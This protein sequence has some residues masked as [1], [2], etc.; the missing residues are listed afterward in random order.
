MNTKYKKISLIIGLAALAGI[1]ASESVNK[2]FSPESFPLSLTVTNLADFPVVFKGVHLT[3]CYDDSGKST[4]INFASI[5]ELHRFVSDAEA[6]AELNRRE[7]LIEISLMEDAA[8]VLDVVDPVVDPVV[9]S[10]VTT[11]VKAKAK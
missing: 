3:P 6:I 2:S 9:E 10:G 5:D 8:P 11:G 1:S 4:L 7:A